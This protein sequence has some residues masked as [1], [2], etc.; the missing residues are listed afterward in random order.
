MGTP[1]PE[2]APR[3]PRRNNIKDVQ[4]ER[5]AEDPWFA[6]GCRANADFPARRHRVSRN[7]RTRRSGPLETP[8]RAG[9]GGGGGGG[10]GAARGRGD[11]APSD[12]SATWRAFGIH[13]AGGG[14]G[15]VNR[16]G[17]HE[18]GLMRDGQVGLAGQP[19]RRP[20]VHEMFFFPAP[21]TGDPVRPPNPVGENASLQLPA[22][23]A[24]AT[25]VATAA[26]G[27]SVRILG[28]ASDHSLAA[29]SRLAL[30]REHM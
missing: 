16:R 4:A 19:N 30:E 18:R 20:R 14:G 3:W 27:G 6:R 11:A 1:R 23:A 13:L 17:P 9:G 15:G 8:K 28:S 7:G 2:R 29:V 5:G 22:A 26:G 25:G 10:G 24:T 12:A 21:P